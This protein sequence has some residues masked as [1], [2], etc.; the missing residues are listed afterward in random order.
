MFKT[1]SNIICILLD[2]FGYWMPLW[3]TPPL[4]VLPNALRAVKGA[5]P[6]IWIKLFIIHLSC[7]ILTLMGTSKLFKL[8]KQ[9]SNQQQ[10][11]ILQ[12]SLSIPNS[13]CVDIEIENI[14]KEN[15]AC[16]NNNNNNTS[17][18]MKATQ[19][20]TNTDDTLILKKLKILKFW[21]IVAVGNI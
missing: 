16:I 20:T 5:T 9:I 18:I 3:L 11:Q 17:P 1:F 8:L 21:G 10:H 6:I 14:Y 4:V 12:R 13:T 19:T 7:Y 2:W 15:N